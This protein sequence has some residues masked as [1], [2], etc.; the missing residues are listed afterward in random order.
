MTCCRSSGSS[1][2]GQRGGVDEVGEQDGD[3]LA[4]VADGLGE[5]PVA[6]VDQRL[7]RRV[8]HLVAEDGALTVQRRDRLLQG[9]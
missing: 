9:S 6:L 4:L 3:D 8:D 5:Q 1:A 2:P 7:Q